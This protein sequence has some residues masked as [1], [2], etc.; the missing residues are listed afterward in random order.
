MYD[1][2]NH[3]QQID[4]RTSN[5][6]GGTVVDRR[7]T[8]ARN[9]DFFLQSHIA[10]Q[11]TARPAHYNVLLDE[12]FKDRALPKGMDFKN[13]QMCWKTSRTTRV[14]FGRATKAVS[15]CPPAYYAD[16]AC[17]RP[18]RYLDRF[19]NTADQAYNRANDNRMLAVALDSDVQVDQKLKNTM[20]YV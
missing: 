9:W 19:Y 20:F 11:G 1:T 15:I 5:P 10:I 17:E 2:G 7:I 4:T 14:I 13:M 3:I 16:I 8:E 18:R 6:V 12:I